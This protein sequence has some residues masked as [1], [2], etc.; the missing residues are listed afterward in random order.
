[1][2]I[3]VEETIRKIDTLFRIGGEEFVIFAKEID[4]NNLEKLANKIR[5]KVKNFEPT[6]CHKFTIS[7][8]ATMFRLDDTKDSIFKRA[9]EALYES[10][11]NGR[12]KVTVV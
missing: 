8:G 6:M 4:E 1:M 7:L 12:N 9:D 3:L 10:K 11:N 5:L 2:V